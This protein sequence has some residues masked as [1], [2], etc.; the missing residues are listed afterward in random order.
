MAASNRRSDPVA[1]A[2]LGAGYI[3]D[4]HF[5]ALRLL[6]HVEVRAICDMNRG[7]AEQFAKAKGIPSAYADLGKMLSCEQLDVVHVLTPPNIHFETG[8]QVIEA[9]VDALIEK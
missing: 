2:L 9:G 6:P 5:S 4:F 7:R 3:A 8:S 1:V